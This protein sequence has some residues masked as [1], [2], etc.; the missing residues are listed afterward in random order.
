M[1]LTAT[2]LSLVSFGLARTTPCCA[3]VT[4]TRSTEV[5]SQLWRLIDNLSRSWQA[6]MRA[7]RGSADAMPMDAATLRD[8]GLSHVAALEEQ[9]DPFA[10]RR[11]PHFWS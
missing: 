2:P 9:S 6:H 1:N 10:E 4:P 5:R 11:R 7:R 3:V 8:L